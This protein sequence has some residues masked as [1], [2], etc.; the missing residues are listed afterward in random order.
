MLKLVSVHIN[1]TAGT[2]F[3]ET[4]RDNY[5]NVF[6]IN[7]HDGPSRA[8]RGQSCDGDRLSANIPVDTDVIHGHFKA[9]EVVCF[10][11]PLITWVRDPVDRVIS[12]YNYLLQSRRTGLDLLDYASQKDSRNRMTKMFAGVPINSFLFIGITERLNEDLAKLAIKFGWKNCRSFNLN[13][14]EY[15]SV[16]RS[17]K[18]TVRNLNLQDV[19]L[20]Q[21]V[22]ELRK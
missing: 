21:K 10:G 22:L 18:I 16:N 17:T 19:E 14:T 15:D 4:L 1:K 2:S 9:S 7:T 12:N 11:A 5:R 13:K 8:R 20:Y 6:R 3:E